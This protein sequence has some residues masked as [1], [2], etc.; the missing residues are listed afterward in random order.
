[1]IGLLIGFKVGT[2]TLMQNTYHITETGIER[3]TPAG[4]TISID[5]DKIDLYKSLKKGFFIKSRNQKILI[6]IGL[7]SYDEITNLI[8]DKVK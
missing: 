3:T 7:D 4:K 1:M 6:P 8:L 5:F 2:K